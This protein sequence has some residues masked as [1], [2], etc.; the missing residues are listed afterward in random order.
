MRCRDAYGYELTAGPLAADAY[1]GGI[2]D[3]LRL[4]TGAADRIASA[5]AFDPT[6]ALGHATLALLGH[7]M[8]VEVDIAARLADARLHAGRATERERSHVHA[9]DR[10]LQGDAAPLVAHLASYPRD[11][12]LLSVAMPTIA[13]AGVTDVPETAWRI[14]EDAAPAYGDDPWITGLM[15]FVRQEQRRFDEAMDLSCRS[16]RAEPSGGHAAHARAH[17]HYET[18]DHTAGLA[19][20]DA[21]I[22]GDGAA[23]DSLTHFSWHAALHELSIGDL[24]AVRARYDAQLQPRHA[25]GCR[26]LVDSGSLLFRWA[27]TPDATGVPSVDE[28]VALT[29]RD[30]L[31]RP[32]TAFLGL[33][34]AVALLAVDDRPGLHDLATWCARHP[35][36]THREVVAP[37]AAALGLLAA[38]CSSAAADRLADLASS[39]WRL[40]GSDAQREI[41]EEARIAALLRAERYDDARQV[42]DARL[43]RRESPRDRR[44]RATASRQAARILS[45]ST[46]M[47]TV[48]SADG[49]GPPSTSPV[50]AE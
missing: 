38:G 39:T 33:H 17:A 32:G 48:A 7:E 18:G 28:V 19:W 31:E 34:A 16:L 40:G 42:L 4:R 41:V 27:I 35:D 25:V 23:T 15:A 1:V 46:V 3:L 21:W 45:P 11:A 44:W 47:S 5:I 37:L 10:H 22:I 50:L 13:F 30:V 26:A 24:A 36:P 9:I 14:V 12:L 43:D 20:M 49:A 6:F 29:G 2:R 8:C